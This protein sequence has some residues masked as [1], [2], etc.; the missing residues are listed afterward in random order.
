[1]L[2]EEQKSALTN[3]LAGAFRQTAIDAFGADV[4]TDN[5]R[6]APLVNAAI[7]SAIDQLD[8]EGATL[9]TE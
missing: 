5:E 6:N 7:R 1:M 2:T 8:S 9:P 4:V 3:R